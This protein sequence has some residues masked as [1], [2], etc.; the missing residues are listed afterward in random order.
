MSFEEFNLHPI[1][2]KAIQQCGYTTPTGVQAEAIPKVLNGSDL[3]ASANTGTGKTAAFVLPALQRL[4]NKEHRVKKQNGKPSVLVLTPTRELANQISQAIRNYGKNLRFFST[5][6]VGGMPYEP[7]LR[8]LS[9]PID[10][11]V[12][13]PGR[14]LDLVERRNID[15]SGVNMLVLD[16]ADRML[17]MG[18]VDEVNKIA[19]FTPETR[20]T[21][22]FSAT[23]DNTMASLARR[24]LKDPERIQVESQVTQNNI[25]QRLHIADDFKHKNRLLLHVLDNEELTQAI[26]FSA[27]KQGANDLA[28]E[29]KAQ[30]HS[31][32]ALHGDMKQGARNR[33]LMNLRR[34]K[35]RL[36]VATDVAAR[37]IDVTTVTH[38]I[39]FDLPRFAEDYVHRIGRT[40]RAGAA[41]TAISFALPD[42]ARHLARI[43]RYTGIQVPQVII[44]GLEPTRSLYQRRTQKKR[45]YRGGYSAAA[46]RKKSGYGNNSPNKGTR[47]LTQPPPHHKRGGGWHGKTVR[48]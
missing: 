10:I 11:V 22:L 41:G 43:E 1:I 36:L 23:W 31:A 39:N 13:T 21:L 7:Q 28:Q 47:H 26:I 15:L 29:L 6:L 44:P 19:S 27:T 46:P 48:D 32:A 34:G 25:E 20:Q 3:I 14:L 5:N 2:L 17:D 42:D 38:V 45:Q 12:A 9:R 16:E 35:L 30:G 33:T 4:T 8:A 40:G 37:G 18:F 24:L